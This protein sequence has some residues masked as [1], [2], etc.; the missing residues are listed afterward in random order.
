[1]KKIFSGVK[2]GSQITAFNKPLPYDISNPNAILRIEF[3]VG[4][5]TTT[6]NALRGDIEVDVSSSG[7]MILFTDVDAFSP[8][9]VSIE[10]TNDGTTAS[11][12]A[13]ATRAKWLGQFTFWTTEQ[14]TTVAASGI[15][16]FN[17]NLSSTYG[18][19]ILTYASMEVIA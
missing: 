9:I 3:A 1:M 14:L 6:N 2:V 5:K 15:K 7:G 11:I 13:K 10:V 4:Y 17:V 16:D 12:T 18:E 19:I 8:L